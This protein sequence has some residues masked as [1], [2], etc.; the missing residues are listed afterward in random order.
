MNT[1]I[2]IVDIVMAD[3][4]E[5]IEMIEEDGRRIFV[6]ATGK[7]DGDW[8]IHTLNP[9][10]ISKFGYSAPVEFLTLHSLDSDF[11]PRK[12]NLAL[13]GQST[14]NVFRL[15]ENGRFK[16][17]TAFFISPTIL[18]TAGHLAPHKGEKVIIQVPGKLVIS[19][20]YSNLWRASASKTADDSEV[21]T[22]KV[23]KT[24]YK[25]KID[26][27]ISILKCSHYRASTWVAI[28]MSLPLN[29]ESTIDLVGYPSAPSIQYLSQVQGFNLSASDWNGVNS[30]LPMFELVV[31]HGKVVQEDDISPRYKLSTTYGMSG[32]AIV[33]QGKVVGKRPACFSSDVAVHSSGNVQTH[34]KCVSLNNILVREMIENLLDRDSRPGIRERLSNMFGIGAF[35][36]E[37]SESSLSSLPR[38]LNSDN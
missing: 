28:D 29:M 5:A 34:N 14:C 9:D 12:D 30:V 13:V 10:G 22:C 2:G 23:L 24:L 35:K 17:G 27:D 25:G 18:L 4:E 32:A 20:H 26:I 31:S 15:T 16:Q 38:Q 36:M 7:F 21:I 1:D 33:F 11:S 3:E 37:H 19:R 8:N 6:A